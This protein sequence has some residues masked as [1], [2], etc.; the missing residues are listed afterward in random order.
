MDGGQQQG[1]SL[2]ILDEQISESK[3][4]KSTHSSSSKG[5]IGELTGF[6]I[7]SN[8]HRGVAHRIPHNSRKAM[9]AKNPL[10]SRVGQCRL[11]LHGLP[12]SLF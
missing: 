8:Q 9:D 6:E 1:F 12:P 7:R 5:G 4:R 2:Q 10:V 11:F 3:G